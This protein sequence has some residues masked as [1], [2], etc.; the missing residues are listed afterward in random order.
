M[1]KQEWI[2]WKTE[3]EKRSVDAALMSNPNANKRDNG[4]SD[5]CKWRQMPVSSGE[6]RREITK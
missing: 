4:A 1:V 5:R 3:L 2:C 6:L